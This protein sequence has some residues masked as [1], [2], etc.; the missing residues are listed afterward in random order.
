M[1]GLISCWWWSREPRVTTPRCPSCALFFCW[2][3]DRVW[4]VCHVCLLCPLGTAP[5]AHCM[6]FPSAS[7]LPHNP[8][9]S[10]G[11]SR[12]EASSPQL[13]PRFVLFFVTLPRL[14]STTPT[15]RSLSCQPTFPLELPSGPGQIEEK[16]SRRGDS[17]SPIK[18]KIPEIFQFKNITWQ[19]HCNTIR[20]SSHIYNVDRCIVFFNLCR[21]RKYL[22]WTLFNSSSF[23]CF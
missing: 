4:P 3:L 15:V 23:H 6:W 22:S 13:V 21:F 17:I 20:I 9:F 14:A 16:Q 2:D 8:R 7:W 1:A 12:T 19:S 18:L 10:P 11:H 5:P